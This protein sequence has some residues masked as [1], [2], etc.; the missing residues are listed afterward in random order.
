MPELTIE[1]DPQEVVG[2]QSAYDPTT[3]RGI[4]LDA[5]GNKIAEEGSPEKPIESANLIIDAV[6]GG[7]VGVLMDGT[8]APH[9][10]VE[11]GRYAVEQG[12]EQAGAGSTAYDEPDAS[13]PDATTLNQ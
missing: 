7:G 10:M 6:V 2:V 9:L 13:I 3:A 8:A 5:Q 11:L 4:V 1:G 12:L